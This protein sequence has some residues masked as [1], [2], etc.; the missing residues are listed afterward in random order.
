[1]VFVLDT[2]KNILNPCSPKR[3][4]ILLT[5]KKAA[6]FR[7]FPFT[8]IL[9]RKV[10]NI[11]LKPLT[12]KLDSGS[13]KTG[14]AIVNN[15]NGQVAFLAEL[16]HRGQTISSSLESR[17][18]IR[19]SRRNR[20]TRYRKCRFFKN[21][22]KK[23]WIAPSLMH[24]IFNISTWISRFSKICNITN[25]SNELVKFD[26][27]LMDNPE[28]SGVE[29]QQG[30]LI[31]YETREYLLEK[32]N[33]QCV[34]CKAVNIPL[35]IEHVIP[36]SRGGTN[37][38]SN[39]TLA[40]RACNLKKGIMTATEFGFPEVEKLAKKSLK[41]ASVMNIIR[42]KLFNQLQTFDLPIECGS[43]GLTKF[44]RT[45][46]GLSKEHFNDALCV[47]KSTP[48]SFIFNDIKALRIKAVGH[49]NRQMCLM[50]KFG[51]SRTRAKGSKKAFGF[52]TG[53]IV[54]A[55]VTKGKKIG[56]YL[57]KV[58]IRT[59]GNFNITTATAVVQGINYKYCKKVHS[60]DGYSYQF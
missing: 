30:T 50:N 45:T 47:G 58:A 53:D 56:N 60:C 24:R 35:E 16:E 5:T 46:R 26:T 48:E 27:Q 52:Q 3:A 18:A 2:E 10:E 11:K 14:I 20:K 29:Y 25:I 59:T 15:N 51:F 54:K 17:K 44:N 42:W 39:L 9:K 31:G 8:I 13:K 23:G 22:N 34:Y 49:G 38:I 21:L 7:M 57:G 37:R 19:R 55:V 40:C 36:K 6:V 32:F 12:I 33:R 4:R 41:D 1:M 43:G 28:I